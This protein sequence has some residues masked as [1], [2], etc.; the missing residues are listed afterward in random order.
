M[1]NTESA[2]KRMRQDARKRV[3]NRGM[4]NRIKTELHKLEELIKAGDRA[5]AA[6]QL[7][8]VHQI[9]DKTAKGNVIHKNTAA[10]KKSQAARLLGTLAA[11]KN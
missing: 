7:K 1:A 11:K 5:A 10:R 4:K 2:K 9:I 8:L 6:T 3:N